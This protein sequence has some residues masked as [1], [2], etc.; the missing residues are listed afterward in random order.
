MYSLIRNPCKLLVEISKR[1]TNRRCCTG[2]SYCCSTLCNKRAVDFYI[3]NDHLI[4]WT[5]KISGLVRK[6]QPQEAIE[7]FRL[8]LRSAQKP[9][10]VTILTVIRAVSA[11][12]WEDLITVVHSLVIRMG[13]EAE[14]SVLT[15]L[16]S[17]YSIYNDMEIVWKLFDQM[18][19]NKDVVFW[20]VMVSACVKNGLY[21]EAIDCFREMQFND[22]KA[23]HVS[24]VSV[25]PACSVLRALSFGR[26]IHG[27]AVRRIFF[28]LTNVQ[29]SLV[30]MYAK[31]GNLD[32]SIRVF[33]GIQHKDVISWRTMIRGCMENGFPSKAL[34]TFSILHLSCSQ[35]DE[36]ILQDTI[37]A[38]VH[39]GEAQSGLALHCYVLKSGFLAFTSVGTSLLHMYAKFGEVVSARNLFDHLYQKDVVAWSAMISV[40]SQNGQA[41]NAF[42]TFKQMISMNKQP[43][44]VTFVSLLQ[45]CS[46]IGAQ[47]LGE[48]IHA[49]VSKQGYSSNVYL[50]S[51]LIDLYCR[52]GRMN[53]GKAVFD[54]ASTKDLICW[55]SMINGYGM[56]GCGIEALVTFSNMLSHGVKP[57]GVIFLA[58]LSACSHCGLEY[59]GWN[60]F[61]SMEKK[62]GIAPKLAHYACMV[63]LLSRQGNI[64][65]AFEF[66]KKMPVEP[67]KRIWGSL[68][69]GCR[70]SCGTIEI[71]EFVVN[72]LRILDPSNNSYY[73]VLLDLYA[74]EQ[75]WDDVERLRRLVNGSLLGEDNSVKHDLGH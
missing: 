39:E 46:S 21:M 47:D 24:V 5:S 1:H 69:A 9:N 70:L 28:H 17:S 71:A 57:N 60:W 72:Q 35:P 65:E 31:C 68:L 62:Y 19:A 38:I 29:N 13:F 51:A 59:E 40:H 66:V 2:I 11:L 36:W 53:Q 20:S 42:E 73:L 25:L 44:E 22:V 4:S 14:P 16:L 75:R 12:N 52:F 8:M 61:Y 64:E 27:F 41:C 48:S 37:S 43:N 74:K 67:D 54:E 15:A 49:L 55:S 32:N 58:V 30:D 45:A 63:D 7:L 26:Q 18:H 3:E 33:S 56:N 6:N 34:G 10:Y 23:N 50:T